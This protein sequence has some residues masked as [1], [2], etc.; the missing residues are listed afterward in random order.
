MT[1]TKYVTE[2]LNLR[3]KFAALTNKYNFNAATSSINKGEDLY[4]TINNLS[5]IGMNVFVMR[6]ES[7]TLINELKDKTYYNPVSFVNAGSGTAAHPTQALLDY[8]TM[9]KHFLDLSDKTVAIVGDIIHS[10]VAKSNIELLKKFNVK[11]N[12]IAPKEFQDESIENVKF[13]TDIKEGFENAD[14]IIALRIQ[15][16]RI[17]EK[18]DF[19]NYIKNYQITKKN[20]P[21][22]AILMHPGPVNKDLEI[23][24]EVLEMQN[25]KTILKQAQNGV[26]IRMSIL[27]ILLSSQGV[28]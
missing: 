19:D 18:I 24:K 16:E 5:A 27:D 9:K 11:I 23:S 7:N 4:D 21:Y 22:A 12:C 10:R 3:K 1:S 8:Y 2:R 25:A 28:Q 20:L 17:S 6:H 13:Y 15:Q 26:Y 14:I